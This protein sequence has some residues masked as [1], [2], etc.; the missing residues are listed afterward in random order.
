[1]RIL[2]VEKP[3][4]E[5]NDTDATAVAKESEKPTSEETKEKVEEPAE[6]LNDTA[7]TTVAKESEKTQTSGKFS[8]ELTEEP[9]KL[10][11]SKQ[12]K[13][14]S[15]DNDAAEDMIDTDAKDVTEETERPE[16]N[17]VVAQHQ[18]PAKDGAKEPEKLTE[19][20]VDGAAEKCKDEKPVEKLKCKHCGKIFLTRY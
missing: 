7:G 8:K 10:E 11:K 4:E 14:R 13:N 20:A 9:K 18:K 3:A 12:N 5:L 6:D 17:L 16:Q 19:K 1:M 15:D 2:D